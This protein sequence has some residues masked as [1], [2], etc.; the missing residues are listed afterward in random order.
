M[1]VMAK[2][3]SGGS[4]SGEGRSGSWNVVSVG[5]SLIIPG[6]GLNEPFLTS[7]TRIIGR[8]ASQ[9]RRFLIVTGGGWLSREYQRLLAK[10]DCASE[11]QDRVGI[12]ATMLNAHLLRSLLEREAPGL[13]APA[14]ITEP[15]R[16]PLP[17]ERRIILAS[18]WKPGASTD[19][20]AAILAARAG[21]PRI[22]NLTSV[23]Y[24]YDLDPRRHAEARRY[25][26]LS[27]REYRSLVAPEWAPGQ[28]APF[29]PVAARMCEEHGIEVAVISGDDEENVAR[30]L[31]G[32]EFRGTLIT[33]RDSP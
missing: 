25:E 31:R 32:E 21:A 15:S 16:D 29:D 33:P 26:L 3:A 14:I 8:L 27:W 5:G 9:E 12:S 1:V 18:G 10:R 17:R 4:A 7:F 19:H 2:K 28:H 23:A 30:A 24:V 11:E 22:I 6:P 20:V 13:V